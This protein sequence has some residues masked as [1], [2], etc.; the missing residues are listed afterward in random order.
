MLAAGR[1][2]R[3]PVALGCGITLWL[4]V[5]AVFAISGRV[6]GARLDALA[7]REFPQS[8]TLD[9][10]LTP[11]P[12]DPVCWDG[13]LVQAQQGQETMRRARISL[14]PGLIGVE[15]CRGVDLGN[16]AATVAHAVP[17]AAAPGIQWRQQFILPADR[18]A[19]L[20]LT[21]CR[22]RAFMQFARLPMAEAAGAD[23]WLGD[24]RF[25]GGR[26]RGFSQLLLTQPPQPCDFAPVPWLPPRPEL[27]EPTGGQK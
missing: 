4:G 9:R 24:L 14:L 7:A 27:L 18:I 19:R 13:W 10:I 17:A 2:L 22:A 11:T 6:A 23:W 25:G 26:G 1:W 8:R 16:A 12:A 21:Q 20:A 3:P 5:T 15:N